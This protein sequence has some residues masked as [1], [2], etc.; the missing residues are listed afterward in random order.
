MSKYR[1]RKKGP[2]FSG[3][4]MICP[5]FAREETLAICCRGEGQGFRLRMG[6]DNAA[7]KKQWAGAHCETFDYWKCP[8]CEMIDEWNGIRENEE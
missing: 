2:H 7:G 5:W 6:F 1:K 4:Q 3:S 8:L